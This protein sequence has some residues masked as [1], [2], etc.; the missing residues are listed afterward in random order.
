MT[1]SQ[2][3]NDWQPL[4]SQ[5]PTDHNQPSASRWPIQDEARLSE[6]R[7]QPQTELGIPQFSP[8]ILQLE[9]KALV[10]VLEFELTLSGNY[11]MVFEGFFENNI[12]EQM[13]S[14]ISG[15][16][17][18]CLQLQGPFNLLTKEQRVNYIVAIFFFYIF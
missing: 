9:N 16:G 11:Q 12:E 2:D 10:I 6:H 8:P 7:I 3:P 13:V 1:E 18:Y 4:L 17:G 5:L 15:D 14:R